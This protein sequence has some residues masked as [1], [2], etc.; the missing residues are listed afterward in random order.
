MFNFFF[1]EWLS[2]QRIFNCIKKRKKILERLIDSE[3]T[4]YSPVLSRKFCITY[5]DN[6]LLSNFSFENT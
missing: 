6:F 1:C 3:E 4:K 2:G 5:R